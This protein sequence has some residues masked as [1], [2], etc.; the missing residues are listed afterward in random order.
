MKSS[1]ALFCSAALVSAASAEITRITDRGPHH[2]VHENVREIQTPGGARFQTNQIIELQG[3]MHRW[4]EQGWVTTDP[5]IEIFGDNA[6]VRNL[7]YGAIFA[8]NLATPGAIDFSLPEGRLTGHLVALALTEGNRSVMIAEVKDC[9]GVIGGPEQNELTFADAFTDFD[10]SVKYAVQRDRISQ[11]VILNQQLPNPAEWQF[12]EDA[13]LEVLTE[14]TAFPDVRKEPREP[15]AGVNSEHISFAT[16]EFITGRA[17]SLGNEA[18]SVVVSKKWE[19]F[20]GQRWF[21]V[22][23]VPW[24]SIAP[25]LANLPPVAK[26]W[27]KKENAVMAR[28]EL[29]L[30]PRREAR[31][32]VKPIQMANLRPA[33]RSYVIDWELVSSTNSFLWKGDTT[34]Y[35]SGSISVKTNV[36]E[37]NCVI[38]FAPTN[39]AKLTI[40]GPAT[41]LSTNYCPVI[42]TARDD[43]SVGEVGGTNALSGVYANTA[44]YFD[45][46]TSGVIYDVHDLRISHADIAMYFNGGQGHKVRNVQV[47]KANVAVY[48]Y[49][50]WVQVLNGLISRVGTALQAGWTSGTTGIFQNVTFSQCYNLGGFYALGRVTNS[51]LIAVTNVGTG[52]SYTG[53]YNGTNSDPAAVFQTVGAGAHYLGTN[54]PFRDAGTANIDSTLLSSL[55]QL[56]TYPPIVI[57][58][59]NGLTIVGNTNLNLSAQAGRDIDVPDMGYHYPPIDFSLGGLYVTNSTI[60]MGV[61]A[62]V[63]T[64]SPTNGSSTYYGIGLDNASTLVSEGSPT[65]LNHV[66]RYNTV[67]EQTGTSWNAGRGEAILLFWNPSTVPIVRFRFTEWSAPAADTLHLWLLDSGGAP[68]L[69]DC[70]FWGGRLW[71]ERPTMST[72]N[73]LLHRVATTVYGNVAMDPTFQNCLFYGGSLELINDLGGT[74]TVKDSIFDKAAISQSGTITHDYNGYVTNASGQWLTGGGGHDSFTNTFT[75]QSGALGRFYQPTNSTF[76]NAGSTNADLLALYHYT[77][78]TNNVKETNSMVDCGFHY[79]ATT[80]GVPI[81]TDGDGI[82]DYLED[83]NGNGSVNS[84]ET[85]LASASDWGLKVLITRPRNGSI[86]P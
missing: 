62:A 40:T 50:S 1:L 48:T 80:N 16:M 13:V 36:F 39:S 41:F 59:A 37:P 24:K 66:V 53:A 15:I 51:L 55:K 81:D 71:T 63:A 25:E 11:I 56:T 20:E 65:N 44:L 72:T 67:Q 27:R 19:L 34:Y 45:N 74:W 12:T 10:I 38:K 79:V 4:T 43:H 17:F 9:V 42:M 2:R 78:L 18:N 54:S 22:E 64:F 7:S 5:K 85:D 28:K 46:L 84:G 52:F 70:Q 21:L 23:K 31:A 68:S 33:G 30:P 14:F 29:R 86:L 26:D 73:C 57:G 49:Q 69:V 61:G 58:Q 8:G 83:A 6:V 32:A 47:V 75:W 77:V 60:T 82:P 3:G 76:L 35:I